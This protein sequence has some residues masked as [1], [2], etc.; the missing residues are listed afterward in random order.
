MMLV[1]GMSYRQTIRACPQGGG[2]YNVAAANLGRVRPEL[3]LTVIVPDLAVRHWWQRL[4][5]EDTAARLR[6]SLAPLPKVIVTSVS[7]HV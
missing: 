7:F 4:L 6:R 5:Y 3:T 2:S 1:V